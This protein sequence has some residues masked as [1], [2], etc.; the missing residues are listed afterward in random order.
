M[1][2]SRGPLGKGVTALGLFLSLRCLTS[3]YNIPTDTWLQGTQAELKDSSNKSLVVGAGSF[4]LVGRDK[5]RTS[6]DIG[7]L[8]HIMID[9]SVVGFVCLLQ[10]DH[11]RV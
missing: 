3:C 6:C 7:G 8:C 4:P 1:R 9:L 5:T 11:F 10:W 2:K